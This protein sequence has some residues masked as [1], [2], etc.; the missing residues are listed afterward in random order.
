MQNERSG[1]VV[2]HEYDGIEECDNHLP[3]WW[4]WSLYLAIVFAAGYWL[5][6]HTFGRQTLASTEYAQV[7]LQR[8]ARE[9]EAL[10]SAGEVNADLLVKLSKEPSTV[11]EGA[12]LY[13][14]NCTVCHDQGGRGKVGPNLTDAYWLHGAKPMDVYAVVKDGFLAKQMP[15]WGTKLGERRVRSVVGYVL[16]IQNTQA[17]GGKAPEGKLVE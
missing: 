7:K 3:R 9:A 8:L 6:F 10:K 17:A 14:Q 13:E 5:V 1:E 12:E 15:A 16:S 4:L 11:A 2:V